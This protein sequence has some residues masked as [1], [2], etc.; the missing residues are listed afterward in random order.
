MGLF[1]REKR[2]QR[3]EE[4]KKAIYREWG[5]V[6]AQG[7]AKYVLKKATYAWALQ[8]FAIYCVLMFLFSKIIPEF[9]FDQYSVLIALVMFVLFGVIQGSME[10]DRNEKIY[11]EKYPYKNNPYRKKK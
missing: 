1:N 9:Y 5:S 8:V 3:F 2:K 10:F 11:R 6:S 7:K 4:Y